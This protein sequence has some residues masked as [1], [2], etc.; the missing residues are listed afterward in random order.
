MVDHGSH[1]VNTVDRGSQPV[2]TVDRGSQPVNTVDRGSRPSFGIKSLY[3]CDDQG[4][5]FTPVIA[6]SILVYKL[7]ARIPVTL[8]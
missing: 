4:K 6:N 2:N 7:Y 3:T 8:A 5:L 1:P